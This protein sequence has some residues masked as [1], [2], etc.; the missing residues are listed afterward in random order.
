LSFFIGEF[1]M[2]KLYAP[3]ATSELKRSRFSFVKVL[4]LATAATFLSNVP[5][6]FS[7]NS[8]FRNT[9]L[10]GVKST[11]VFYPQNIVSVAGLN[12]SS[13]SKDNYLT[14]LNKAG[15]EKVNAADDYANFLTKTLPG[16]SDYRPVVN[17]LA[18]ESENLLVKKTR[19]R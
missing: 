15:A 7:A 5:P 2:K 18:A 17:V 11:G 10:E 4:S 12:V 8:D 1:V 14:A 3:Q 19:Y 16:V 9:F 6:V 13:V